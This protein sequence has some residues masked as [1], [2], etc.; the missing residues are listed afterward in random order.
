MEK[1]K[2]DL[3]NVHLGEI[4]YDRTINIHGRDY[5]QVRHGGKCGAKSK[6]IFDK[7]VEQGYDH[8]QPRVAIERID[9]VIMRSDTSA[10]LKDF[11]SK[12][13]KNPIL[14]SEDS[15]KIIGYTNTYILIDGN[16]R[17]NSAVEAYN[18]YNKTPAIAGIADYHT[19]GMWPVEI[20]KFPDVAAKI[21]FQNQRNIHRGMT[22]RAKD[23][24]SDDAALAVKLMTTS[25]H[26][27]DTELRNVRKK[28][29]KSITN[30]DPADWI[31]TLNEQESEILQNSLLMFI[32]QNSK[33][34]TW[35]R[36]IDKRKKK[37]VCFTK[38]GKELIKKLRLLYGLSTSVVRTTNTEARVACSGRFGVESGNYNIEGEQ[39]VR[40]LEAAGQRTEC[41]VK[42]V[43]PQTLGVCQFAKDYIN[44]AH[45]ADLC[46]V[47][48]GKAN[49]P[50]R[51]FFEYTLVVSDAKS[52]D[53]EELTK[54]RKD[55]LDTVKKQNDY[56]RACHNTEYVTNVLFVAQTQDEIKKFGPNGL[57]VYKS[58]EEFRSD[59]I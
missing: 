46:V 40:M 26:L 42:H 23:T 1:K 22:H 44:A 29:Y 38:A 59:K 17:V 34:D 11:L 48:E 30:N 37:E 57:F 36:Y 35:G 20:M 45:A 50:R 5:I 31:K 33:D 27:F 10:A 53:K 39:T 58:L 21:S 8:K 32:H 55:V 6:E 12:L 4:F 47:T 25:P 51:I 15:S 18:N 56:A 9:E 19:K 54:F 41:F 14:D 49:P 13:P 24:L 7:I 28:H 52:L 16:H 43:H 2:K 3:K